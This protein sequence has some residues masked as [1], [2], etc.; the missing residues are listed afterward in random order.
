MNRLR[1]LVCAP[2]LP[3]FDRESGGQSIFD[4]IMFLRDA[5]WAVSFAAQNGNTPTSDH[6]VP[7]LQQRGIAPYRS[8]GPRRPDAIASGCFGLAIAALWHTGEQLLPV[9]RSLSPATR[10]AINTMDLHF[11]RNAR[12]VLS[13]GAGNNIPGALDERYSSEMT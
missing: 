9:F 1:A 3:E 13:R 5:G 6:Y 2:H 7:I 12:R 4:L 10:V 11:M 8:F